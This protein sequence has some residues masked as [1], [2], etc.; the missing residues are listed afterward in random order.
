[1]LSMLLWDQTRFFLQE[2]EKR[3]KTMLMAYESNLVPP[4]ISRQPKWTSIFPATH[5]KE[6]ISERLDTLA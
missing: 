5:G 4:S 3:K 2:Q 6:R 1:M